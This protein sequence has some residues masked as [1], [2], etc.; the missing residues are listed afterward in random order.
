MR[1]NGKLQERVK[2]KDGNDVMLALWMGL[3]I[4]WLANKTQ[5]GR[6]IGKE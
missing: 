4:R 2:E 5:N 3:E 6:E 1:I